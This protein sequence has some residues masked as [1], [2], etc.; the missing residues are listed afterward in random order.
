MPLLSNHAFGNAVAYATAQRVIA[1]SF[2]KGG[3]T[4]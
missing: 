3:I 2:P 1:S 4:A